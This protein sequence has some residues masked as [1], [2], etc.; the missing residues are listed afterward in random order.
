M[1]FSGA[2][3]NSGYQA[4]FPGLCIILEP[5]YDEANPFSGS[6]SVHIVR[7]CSLEALSPQSSQCYILAETNNDKKDCSETSQ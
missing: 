1:K 7:S 2:C 6:R 4:L 3:T 5:G